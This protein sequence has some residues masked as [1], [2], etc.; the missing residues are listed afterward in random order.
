MT[1]FN[2]RRVLR[3]ML[4]GSAVTVALPFLNCFLNGNGTALASGKPLPVRFGTWTWGL[5]ISKSV[6]VPKKVG[7]NY[8]F[9]EEIECLKP[10]QNQINVLTNYTAFRDASENICHYTGWVTTRTGQAPAQQN[11]R[12]GETLDVT[13]A[14]KIGRTTRFKMLTATATGDGRASLS[15]EGQTS[16]VPAE[17]SPIDFYTR[18]FGPSFPDPNATTFTPNPRIMLRRS[19]LSAVTDDIKDINR[20]VGAEDKARLDQY[21]TGLRAI[22]H[23]MDQQLAKPEP[24]A[25]CHPGTAADHDPIAGIEVKTLSERHNM[26]ADLLAMAIACDQTRVFNMFY[27]ASTANTVKQ[28]YEKPHHTC[29][30]EEPVDAALGYQPVVSWFT[31]RS[32]ESWLYFVQAFEK[33][34]EGDGS[35]LDNMLIYGHSEQGFARIHSLD[36]LAAFTA[37]RAGGKVKTGYHIDGKDSAITEIGYT[38]MR[39]MG[40]DLPRWGTRSNTTSK[41]ISDILV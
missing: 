39:V 6:F 10:I 2:R 18:L 4:G 5:G 21:F 29:T 27:A 13:I 20:Y 25:A 22:E 14:N 40:L 36:G 37:G 8:E 3:G 17:S 41:V 9:P 26:M 19:A 38:A 24:L 11:D 7:T 31:R 30:H 28:G 35:L 33:I 16:P 32:M 23:Q 1:G 12:P 15:Y 34:K